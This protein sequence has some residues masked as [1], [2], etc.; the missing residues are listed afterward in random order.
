MEQEITKKHVLVTGAYGGMGAK[1][2]EAFVQK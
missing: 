2:V 1:V